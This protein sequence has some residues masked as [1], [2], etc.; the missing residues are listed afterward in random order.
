MRQLLTSEDR[1]GRRRASVAFVIPIPISTANEE[2]GNKETAQ[3]NIIRYI[4]NYN[5]INMYIVIDFLWR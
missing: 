3:M 1:E 5:V 2:V 4:I